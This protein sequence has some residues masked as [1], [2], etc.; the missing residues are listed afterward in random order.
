[1]H[2]YM[3]SHPHPH[4][5]SHPHQVFVP[6]DSVVDEFEEAGGV[7]SADVCSY[8]VVKGQVSR[9]LGLAVRTPEPGPEPEPEPEPNWRF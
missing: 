2:P 1:M 8:H 4:P 3:H 6:T 7:L 5:H 9:P